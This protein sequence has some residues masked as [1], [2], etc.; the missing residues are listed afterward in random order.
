MD[1]SIYAENDLNLNLNELAHEA[2]RELYNAAKKISIYSA[3]HPVSQKAVGRPF[4]LMEKAFKFKRFFNLHIATGQLYALNIRI[5]LSV[6]SEQIMEY[7]QA[8]DLKDILFEKGLTINHLTLFLERFVKKLPYADY[9]NLMATYLEKHKID[10]IKVNSEIGLV[11]FEK[12]KRFFG[13]IAGDFSVRNMAGEVMGNKVELLIGMLAGEDLPAEQYI[14]RNRHD[15]APR[16]V[17]VLLS[18]KIASMEKESLVRAIVNSIGQTPPRADGIEGG[19]LITQAA[20]DIVGILNYHPERDDIIKRVGDELLRM[21]FDRSE[22]SELFPPISAIKLESS[23]KI[24]QFLSDAFVQESSQLD[25]GEFSGRFSQLLRTGQQGKAKA[26]LKYLIENLAGNSRPLRQRA[27]EMLEISLSSYRKA[28]GAFMIESLISEIDG[29]F[30]AGA[31]T[32]EFSDLIWEIGKICLAEKNYDQLSRLCDVI[33]KR[34]RRKDGIRVYDSL[35]VK[36]AADELNRREVINQLVW[37]LAEGHG[38]GFPILKNILIT[39]GSEEVAMALSHFISH[40][41][42]QLRQNILKILSE[43]GKSSLKVF[44][45]ILENDS[46]FEREELRRELPDSKWY[47]IRNSIFV[48]GAL[49]DPEGCRALRTRIADKDVRIRREI[50][51]ALEKIGGEQAIDLLLIMAEDSEREI[52]EASIIAL[53]IIGNPDIV[54]EL[55]DLARR[56]PTEILRIIAALGKLGG[57]EA[58]DFLSNLLIDYQLQSSLT[59]N[60][61]SRDELK[62]ATI[63]ALGKIG[64]KKA[65]DSIRSFTDTLSTTQRIFF[66]GKIT[67]VVEDILNKSDL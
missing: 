23:E 43:L 13:D 11:L 48:L 39:I 54:P 1:D 26:V 50:V 58:R 18:E 42:R 19:T 33:S 24:D 60:R 29:Y 40:E 32:F 30:S 8:L 67:K 65:L 57:P 7:M 15:Y 52:C 59:S 25:M 53:S 64:D 10:S 46:Y 56:R 66:S 55:I 63:K 37:E 3:A 62:L 17:R 28:T 34:S 12:G 4:L 35:T 45:D 20:R 38:A 27:L 16:L 36:K 22:F 21:G 31:E 44:S 47:I 9:Q 14:Y 41:S 51:A 2:I 49:G 61:S 6:F 5:R